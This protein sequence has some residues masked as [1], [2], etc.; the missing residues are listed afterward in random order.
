MAKKRMRRKKHKIDQDMP[1]GELKRVDDFLPLHSEL[2]E[3]VDELN[4]PKL[5]KTI[6]RGQRAICR[7]TRGVLLSSSLKRHR[8]FRSA[9]PG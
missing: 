1:I 6:A 7:G 5:L 4:D 3:I 2:S 9:S 8:K